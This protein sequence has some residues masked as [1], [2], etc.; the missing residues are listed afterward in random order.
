MLL[1]PAGRATA[2]ASALRRRIRVWRGQRPCGSALLITAAGSWMIAL[3]LLGTPMALLQPG[4][5]GNTGL[6]V[7]LPLALC[8]LVLLRFP[9]LH[10][11]VGL[12]AVGL[13]V[14]SLLTCNLGGLLLGTTL[15]IVGGCL[16]FSWTPPRAPHAPDA[17]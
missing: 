16:A 1:V 3:P 7:S 10:A 8:G 6:G 15:G 11:F 14:L 2:G 5:A 4:V 13:A 9:L 12:A 17:S